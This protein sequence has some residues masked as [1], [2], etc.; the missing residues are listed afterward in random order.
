LSTLRK[1]L[2]R[3][4]FIRIPIQ[5]LNTGH[6][7][8]KAIVNEEVGLFILDTGAS[9]SCICLDYASKFHLETEETE[10]QAAGAGATE[11]ETKVAKNN[12]IQLGTI[13]LQRAD[14][15]LFHMIHVNNA[16]EQAGENRV[17][18]ILGADILEKLHSVI[19]YGRN[20]VYFK[21]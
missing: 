13:T 17:H 3:K 5:K 4:G 16:L 9:S 10:I 8:F 21:K 2:E 7:Q 18:G 19:D 11:M 1:L 20:C 15:V 14:I 6:Y 12:R